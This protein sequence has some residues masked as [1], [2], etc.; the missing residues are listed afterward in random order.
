MPKISVIVPVYKVEPYLC[1]CVDS[2]LAQTFT[3]YELFLVDDGSPDRCGEICDEYAE[4][5]DRIRVIHKP[6]GGLSDAR[7]AALDLMT[8]EYVAFIDSDDWAAPDMLE[9][10][11]RAA[12]EHQCD[13]AVC[14]ICNAY[15][16]GIREDLY[17]P[18]IKERVVEGEERYET[19]YQ[20]S[21]CNKL[22]K[23]YIFKE[24]RYPKGRMYEDTFIYH[25]ILKQIDKLVYT[26][27]TSYFYFVR[28]DSIMNVRYTLQSADI[29][30]AVYLR[31]VALDEAGVHTHADEA[32]R[33]LY[34]RLAVAY[35]RLDW[36]DEAVKKHL[37]ELKRLYN[38]VFGRMI[39]DQHFSLKQKLRVL[40]LFIS[41]ALHRALYRIEEAE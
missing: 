41:P 20:P 30:D 32:Y 40:L 4:K 37:G 39:L 8:G 1:R 38:G 35:E 31:A 14:N 34:S 19:L 12:V 24:L 29:V 11:Y 21:A 18:A 36:K 7:N 6:N 5:D 16:G 10:M 27:K 23:S 22:Y 28:T 17:V 9:S 26:G 25:D 15:S 33:A 2:I 3:D 13:M